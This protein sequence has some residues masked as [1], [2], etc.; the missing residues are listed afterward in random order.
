[1][2]GRKRKDRSEEN[3][4]VSKRWRRGLCGIVVS[5]VA[6]GSVTVIHLKII[7]NIIGGYWIISYAIIVSCILAV[8][9]YW[10]IGL[11]RRTQN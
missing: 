9:N 10:M 7:R 6:T 3:L 8:S 5:G 2:R 11:K 4:K 1:M